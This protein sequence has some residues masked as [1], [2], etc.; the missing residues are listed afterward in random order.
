MCLIH[1]KKIIY[2]ITGS[3]LA[4]VYSLSNV[5]YA[6]EQFVDKPKLIL[7]IT[8][9]QLRGDLPT[10][11][12]ERLGQDGFRYLWENG[13]VYTNAHHAHA[14]TETIVGHVTLATG[15][16]PS[17]HGMTGNIWLDRNSNQVTYNIED[18]DYQLLT[19][20]VDLVVTTAIPDQII[21]S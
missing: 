21:F 1:Y 12:Y 18:P 6:T 20:G 17:I 14:N 8:V 15:S 16:H 7:Q 19:T 10:R 11:Y 3:Y 13:L 5:L 9:D 4:V 2:L